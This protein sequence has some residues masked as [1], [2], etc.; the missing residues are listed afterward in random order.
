[1]G[2][3]DF[4]EVVVMKTKNMMAFDMGASSGRGLVGKFD[5]NKIDVEILHQFSNFP[6]EITGHYYWD[7]LR[8]YQE[9]KQSL[10][11]FSQTIGKDLGGIAIDTWGV[12]YGLIDRQGELLGNPYSYRDSRV[13]GM[14]DEAFR[15]ISKETIYQKTGIAFMWFNTIYQLLATRCQQPEMFDNASSLL[16]MPDLLSYFLCGEKASEYTM[17]STGQCVE[18]KNRSWCFEILNA[19]EIPDKIFLPLQQPGTIRGSLLPKLAEEVGLGTVPVIAVGGHDTAS[20]V[21]AV[22]ASSERFA[23]ISS[24]TWSLFGTEIPEAIINEKT[25]SR[26]F[27]NEGG[28]ENTFRL[29]RNVMGLWIIQECRRI[30][31]NEGDSMS[32]DQMVKLAESAKPFTCLIDPDNLVFAT[33][34]NMPQRI[35]EFCQKTGQPVPTDKG[36]IIRCVYE[37]LALRYRHTMNGLE[38]IVGYS[39]PTLHIVGG[40]SKNNLLNQFTADALNRPVICGPTEATAIGNVMIQA[41]AL[42]LVKDR[43]E[44]RQI[45]RNSFSLSTFEPKNPKLWDDAFQRFC[46]LL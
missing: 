33:P 14:F 25:L 44:I 38:E 41:K 40:G 7:V 31:E 2:K 42:G 46:K 35:Q 5:G 23:Y 26:N 10:L 19:L 29:L 18:T 20:A 3:N 30:W 12:D 17:A 45:I 22:P 43:F 13:D 27:T 28:V 6:V 9:M 32:F 11:K 24:G 21:V 37:S 15:R 16:H 1:M 8:L 4:F 39:L 36:Q 34:G